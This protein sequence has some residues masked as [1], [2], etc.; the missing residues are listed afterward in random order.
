[1]TI[2]FAFQVNTQEL[3]TP[4]DIICVSDKLDKV[5]AILRNRATDQALFMSTSS[6][7]MFQYEFRRHDNTL[8]SF[9]AL[10]EM[11]LL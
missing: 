11:P 9:I 2:H 6:N 1:M 8:H 3:P 5:M 4:D 10:K 7:P